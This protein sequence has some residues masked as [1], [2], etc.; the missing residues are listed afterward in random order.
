[1]LLQRL[2]GLDATTR[3]GF[4]EQLAG[5]LKRHIVY[6]VRRGRAKSA[7]ARP[8]DRDLVP[9]LRA[10]GE[11]LAAALRGR[12]SLK[13]AIDGIE[14]RVQI[15]PHAADILGAI[16]GRRTIAEVHRQLADKVEALKTWNAF[17]PAFERVYHTFNNLNR[18]FLMRGGA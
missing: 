1:G 11:D 6:L 12:G 5:N 10:G 4:A 18:L 13:V 8:D 2:S 16:D 7:T 15:P 17:K 9:V 14:L 3:A